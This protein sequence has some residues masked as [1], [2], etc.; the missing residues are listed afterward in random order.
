MRESFGSFGPPA[1]EIG[2]KADYEI[3]RLI[4][5]YGASAIFDPGPIKA[6][7]QAVPFDRESVP[8]CVICRGRFVGGLWDRRTASALRTTGQWNRPASPPN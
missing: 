1:K 3:D 5:G 2:K 7:E 8:E 6:T 4:L